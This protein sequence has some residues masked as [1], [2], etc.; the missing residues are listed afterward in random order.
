MKLF[1]KPEWLRPEINDPKYWV[2]VGV[3]VIIGVL[4]FNYYGYFTPWWVL[5]I[6]ITMGDIVA[7]TVLQLD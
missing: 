3:L 6:A 5:L 7:H 4:V 1:N 2:H